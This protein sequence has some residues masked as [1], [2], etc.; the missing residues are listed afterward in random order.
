MSISGEDGVLGCATASSWYVQIFWVFASFQALAL[1]K[2][3]GLLDILDRHGSFH[4]NFVLA[5]AVETV[6]PAGSRFLN[7]ETDWP[8]ND[9]SSGFQF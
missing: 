4:L 6:N 3:K 1:S 8:L 7:V 5:L 9:L 2:Q